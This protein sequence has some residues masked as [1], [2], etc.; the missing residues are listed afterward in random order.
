[1]LRSIRNRLGSLSHYPR[2]S[3]VH[4]RPAILYLQFSI[5]AFVAVAV[6]A[7]E[8]RPVP[9]MQ[10]IPL[11]DHQ[12]SFQRDG[13]EIIRYYFGPALR[14]PFLY[15]VVGPSGRSLTRMG[16]P[17]DP[18]SHSHHNSIWISH[19]DVN[20]LSFWGDRTKGRIAH[21][22]VELLEDGD[23]H[24]A[25]VAANAWINEATNKVLL[26]ERRRIEVRLLPNKEWLLILDLNFDV[27]DSDVVLGKTPFGLVGVRMAKTI[28][29]NDGGGELRN[30]EGESGEKGIFWKHA[31]W[32]DYSGPI[33]ASATEGIT[34]MDH[35]SNPN[36]PTGF[37]VR[38]DGWMG[39]SLTLDEARTIPVGKPLNLRYGL[40]IHGGMQDTK[41]LQQRWDEFART[42]P[43]ERK[44]KK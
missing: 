11:P 5:L 28:G 43:P 3:I 19:N 20:G 14:R 16:H 30:S 22:R 42:S 36:H 21:Q 1:M 29:I 10:A 26:Q 35:P 31:K 9:V 4:P 8:P 18:E 33:T 38:S 15:P 27:K 13:V 40:Y 23:D 37:H 34:L 7:N 39:T 32:V 6:S 2:P 41:A 24:A 17:H 25:I 12:I 44:K